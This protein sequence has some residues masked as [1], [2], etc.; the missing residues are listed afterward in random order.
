MPARK[1]DSEANLKWRLPDDDTGNGEL[2]HMLAC[3]SVLKSSSL[4]A[5][6]PHQRKARL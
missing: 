2:L 5:A 3:C 4:T 1:A 6:R